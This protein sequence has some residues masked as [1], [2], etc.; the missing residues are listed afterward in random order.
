MMREVKWTSGVLVVLAMG[1]VAPRPAA[2]AHYFKASNTDYAD[3]F[4]CSLAFDGATL[5]VGARWEDSGAVGVDGDQHDESA[6]DSGAVYVY[7]RSGASWVQQAY[8]KPSNT[9]PEDVFGTSVSVSGDTIAVGAPS[10]GGTGAAYVFTR[11]GTTWHQQAYLKASS[12]GAN[13]RFGSSV[14]LDHET[15]VVGAFREDSAAT[16][17]NGDQEDES[18]SDAGAVYVFVRDGTSWQQQAYIKASNTTSYNWFGWSL[19][20]SDDTLVVGAPQESEGAPGINGDD[21][22]PGPHYSGASYIYLRSGNEWSQQAF[23]KST[24]PGENDEFGQ[25]V[26]IRGDTVAVGARYET[27][28]SEGVK[29]WTAGAAY[30]YARDDGTWTQQAYLR[31][32]NPGKYDFFGSSVSVGDEVLVVGA[33]GE[34][35]SAV[36]L[37]GIEDEAALQ[38]GA[39]YAFVHDAGT[40]SQVA[41]AKATNSAPWYEFG[42]AVGVAG[43]VMVVGSPGEQSAGTGVDGTQSD[44]GLPHAGAAYLYDLDVTPWLPLSSALAGTQGW[45]VLAGAGSAL[46][47]SVCSLALSKAAPNSP[48]LLALALDSAPLPFKGGTLV[49][50]P[51]V[52]VV[53]QMT[54]AAGTHNQVFH[55]PPV[56][57]G[58]VFHFQ[59]AITDPGAVYGVALSN[60]L[61]VDV[62]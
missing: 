62:P 7:V 18:A 25:S 21:S 27:F 30:V 26:S 11:V 14:S 8:L 29:Y 15:L 52:T 41:Y 53:A 42:S 36:G 39:T 32:S 3:E 23:V 5:V 58:S 59:Y 16:G 10:E 22:V 6:G 17:V 1:A 47:A 35:G 34:D 33:P 48:A 2:Q 19:S 43:D 37:N 12:P 45:P 24:K 4:G 61:R 40:W 49:A 56:P 57:S 31:A 60:A 50:A 55:W 54:D 44:D 9:T 46:P 38:A 51:V 28:L 20:L 13:D